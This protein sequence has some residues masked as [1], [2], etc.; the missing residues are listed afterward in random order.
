MNR[1]VLLLSFLAVSLLFTV[2]LVD[3]TSPMVWL[4]STSH[5]YAALRLVLLVSFALLLATA[6]P[7]TPFLRRMLGTVVLVVA[8]FTISAT[9]QN[10]MKLLDTLSLLEFTAAA[11]VAVLER[12]GEELLDTVRASKQS[13][14]LRGQQ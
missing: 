14:K 2:S 10:Q 3:P 11:G 8:A 7:R 12:S 1:F 5:G 13:L 9:Y 6:P 4:A